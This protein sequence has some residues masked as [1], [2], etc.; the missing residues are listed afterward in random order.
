VVQNLDINSLSRSKIISFGAPWF[1]IIVRSRMYDSFLVVLDLLYDIMYVY[2]VSLS[3]MTRIESYLCPVHDSLEGGNLITKSIVI[4][5]Q[6]C[7][8]VS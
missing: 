2:F 8:G 7:G 3:V 5:F 1:T 6:G 4:D